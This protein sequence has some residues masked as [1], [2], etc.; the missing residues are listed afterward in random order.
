MGNFIR[1]V[2][3][4]ASAILQQKTVTAQTT[5]QTVSPDDGYDGL[6]SVVVNPQD[7]NQYYTPT[8]MNDSGAN[9]DMGAHHNNRYVNTTGMYKPSGTYSGGSYTSNGTKTITGLENY[10]AASFNVNVSA[11]LNRSTLWTNSYPTSTFNAQTITISSME[12]YTYIGF[13]YRVSTDNSTSNIVMITLS[14]FKNCTKTSGR[15]FPCLGALVGTVA[16]FRGVQYVSF[17]EIYFRSASRTGSTESD[18]FK[19]IPTAVYGWK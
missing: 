1:S 19:V 7:H 16:S 12:S 18:N 11:S 3:S 9:N 6:S 4:A 8:T 5:Q 2:L 15:P 14:S 10:A 17:T 13:E